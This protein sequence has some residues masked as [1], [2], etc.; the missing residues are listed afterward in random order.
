MHPGREAGRIELPAGKRVIAHLGPIPFRD[1]RAGLRI[2]D[3]WV[4]VA[5]NDDGLEALRAHH[6]AHAHAGRL[7]TPLTDDAGKAHQSLASRADD[8]GVDVRPKLCLEHVNRLRDGMAPEI[9]GRVEADLPI[10]DDG[11]DGLV[12]YA[13]K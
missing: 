5:P 7:V 11:R 1:F 9:T 8:G 6:R 10:L 12:G 13:V 3:W 2:G 4:V